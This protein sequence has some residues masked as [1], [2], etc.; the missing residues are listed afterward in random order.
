MAKYLRVNQSSF[1]DGSNSYEEDTG[2][3]HLLEF[4]LSQTQLTPTLN[5]SCSG[6]LDTSSKA[7][8]TLSIRP[9]S[10]TD[11]TSSCQIWQSIIQCKYCGLLC[12]SAF[13]GSHP[14][15]QL[16]EQYA[17][18]KFDSVALCKVINA[19]KFEVEHIVVC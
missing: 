17:E 15:I 6:N 9:K 14:W 11:F 1:I 4:S 5:A 12:A 16:N 3:S 13:A 8:G 7:L 18:S 19:T 10:S 2:S